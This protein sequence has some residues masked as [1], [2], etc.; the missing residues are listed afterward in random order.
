MTFS[1]YLAEQPAE[2]KKKRKLGTG[3]S[4]IGKT[5]FD[6][7]DDGEA[8]IISKPIPG[9]GL[10][11]ARIL[12]KSKGALGGKGVNGKGQLGKVITADGGFQFSPLKRDRRAVGAS[13]L[14]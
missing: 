2:K 8:G 11:A 9:R 3:S 5:L 10:F 13:I 4:G 7:E 1:S 14:E 12:A 6:E